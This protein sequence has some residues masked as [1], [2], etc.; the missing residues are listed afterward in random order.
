MNTNW[1]I[2][3]TITVNLL[4][5]SLGDVCAKLWGVTGNH[6]WFYAG[7]P[8]SI[9]TILSY[10]VI[11][12]QGGLAVPTTIV[13]ILTIILNVLIGFLI[14]HEKVAAGQWVGIALGVLSVLFTAGII[15][16]KT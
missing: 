9:I 5:S 3:I 15:A 4:F 16:F 14:F 6:N 8:I 10:M 12:K 2:F 11:V 1:P 13:L 7:I